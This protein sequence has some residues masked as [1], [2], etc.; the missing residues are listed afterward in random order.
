[1]SVLR[2]I[3]SVDIF[4]WQACGRRVRLPFVSQL[5]EQDSPVFVFWDESLVSIGKR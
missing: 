3:A 2:T 4:L 1:M 5:H